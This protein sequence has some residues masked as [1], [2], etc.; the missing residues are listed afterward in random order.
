MPR[1][2]TICR[3]PERPAIN[4]SLVAGEP[5][6]SIADHFELSASALKR[7]R[8]AHLPLTLL[9]AAE[10]A[11]VAEADALLDRVKETERRARAY[12][13]QAAMAGDIRGALVAL[14]EGRAT[15][16]LLARMAGELE[17]QPHEPVPTILWGFDASGYPDP[18]TGTESTNGNNGSVG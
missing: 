4:A 3:H 10:A 16:E 2:C 1:T 12:E 11:E 8:A 6:R 5:F 15:L 18:P 13:A 14:R 7:H 17:G 9:R